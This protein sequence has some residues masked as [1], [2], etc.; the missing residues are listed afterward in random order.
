MKKMNKSKNQISRI[1]KL[2]A[3]NGVKFTHQRKIIADVI[4]KSNDHPDANEVYLR[5]NKI[6][7]RISLATV[8]RTI[9]LFEE[10]NVLNRIELG[11]KRARYEELNEDE[12]HDHLIDIDSGEIIEFVNEEIES[13]QMKVAKKLGYELVDHRMELFGKKIQK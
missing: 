13:L 3:E 4:S 9:K 5:A 8:Y 11:G 6:D 1:E 12:H 7:P 10:H 2:C